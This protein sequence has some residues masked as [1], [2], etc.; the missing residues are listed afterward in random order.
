[1]PAAVQ[2]GAYDIGNDGLKL[3]LARSAEPKAYCD[4]VG[5]IQC[6]KR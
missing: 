6:V 2:F 1:M 4:G 5:D 3:A